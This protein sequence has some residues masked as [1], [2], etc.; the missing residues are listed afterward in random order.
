[1]INVADIAEG[2][3]NSPLMTQ[4]SEDNEQNTPQ[5]SDGKPQTVTL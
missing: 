4:F 5:S 1:M 3:L 2:F